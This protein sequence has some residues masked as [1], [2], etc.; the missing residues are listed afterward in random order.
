[1]SVL[2]PWTVG[3]FEMLYHAEV[4]FLNGEDSDR[5]IALISFDNTIEIS[6]TTYLSL[7][8]SQRGER[9]Y[10]TKDIEKWLQKYHSKINFFYQEIAKRKLEI[11]VEKDEVIYYHQM[12]NDQYHGGATGVPETFKLEGIREAAL[13]VF[14]VLFDTPRPEELLESR[15]KEAFQEDKKTERDPQKDRLID[16]K[17][18]MADVAGILFHSSEVLFSLDHAAYEEIGVE[19]FNEENERRRSEEVE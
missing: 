17:F 3:P 18:G 10:Q 19:L 5:R 4:H 1:M 9:E 11:I 6:I 14:S 12:R 15:I 13:W 2:K 7:H 8:P 16:S